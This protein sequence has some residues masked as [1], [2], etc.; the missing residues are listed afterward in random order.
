MWKQPRN[1]PTVC[2]RENTAQRLV[3]HISE[4]LMPETQCC[5][6]QNRSASDMIFVARQTLEKSREQYRDLHMCSVDL[7]KAF[8]TVERSMLWEK[9]LTL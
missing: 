7:S 9:L 5:F 4:D 1:I 3:E 2:R 8:D 6:R